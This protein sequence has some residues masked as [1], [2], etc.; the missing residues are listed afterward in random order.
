MCTKATALFRGRNFEVWYTTRIP[1]SYGPWLLW[2]LPGLIIEAR[3]QDGDLSF[4]YLKH[5]IPDKSGV[6]LVAPSSGQKMSRKDFL[7][8][9]EELSKKAV[10]VLSSGLKEQGMKVEESQ[11]K[12][13]EVFDWDLERMQNYCL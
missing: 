5:S 1:V 6:A 4:E 3:S 10:E 12:R 7:K 8:K 2:G 13:K 9:R 11:M